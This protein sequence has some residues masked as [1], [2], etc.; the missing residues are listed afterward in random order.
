MLQNGIVRDTW[1]FNG[2][3]VSDCD[4]VADAYNAH[5]YTKLPEE[6]VADGLH[7]GCDLDC[8]SF[9]NEHLND[10]VSKGLVNETVIDLALERVFTMRFI[11][12]EFDPDHLVPYRSLTHDDIDTT[13]A[14]A[15]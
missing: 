14:R 4:A 11:M 15:R 8:G 2:S 3:I 1:G 12:G 6:T 10:A 7:G 13:A 5:G 9:Y